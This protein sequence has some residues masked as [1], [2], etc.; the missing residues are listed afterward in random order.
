[1]E[2]EVYDEEIDSNQVMTLGLVWI[3]NHANNARVQLSH[4]LKSMYRHQKGD[5]SVKDGRELIVS[6]DRPSA[7]PDKGR[8]IIKAKR[9]PKWLEN[10]ELHRVNASTARALLDELQAVKQVL[11]KTLDSYLTAIPNWFNGIPN[12]S[13]GIYDELRGLGRIVQL[14][15]ET[16]RSVN[17][18]YEDVQKINRAA[19]AVNESLR[20]NGRKAMENPEKYLSGLWLPA[21][22]AKVDFSLHFSETEQRLLA[23]VNRT[24]T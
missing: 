19:D 20:S 15:T 8:W 13:V 7:G 18:L 1:M 4:R 22:F 21:Y 3:D 14:G 16:A 11:E 5:L 2:Y 23:V 24:I 12:V 17:R 10:R 9:R 6:F